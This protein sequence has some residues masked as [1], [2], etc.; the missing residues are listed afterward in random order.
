MDLGKNFEQRIVLKVS[1]K[2]NCTTWYRRSTQYSASCV[3]SIPSLKRNIP[4]LN[5]HKEI[6]WFIS[7]KRK[8]RKNGTGVEH[9]K[10]K[11]YLTGW[12]SSLEKRYV[13]SQTN[14]FTNF[15]E[16]I[17]NEKMSN[18]NDNFFWKVTKSLNS[19]KSQTT[20]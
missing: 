11:E 9:R 12:T 1:L 16:E 14:L 2:T 7:N 4:G 18:D 3:Q 5:Y 13:K 17:T 15:L 19:Q 6:R 10:T 20:H 8:A